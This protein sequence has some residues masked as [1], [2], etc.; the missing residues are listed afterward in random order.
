MLWE[1]NRSLLCILR[2]AAYFFVKFVLLSLQD[3]DLKWVEE[4]IPSSM[5]DV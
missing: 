5:A 3:E 2:Y 1:N 4:N